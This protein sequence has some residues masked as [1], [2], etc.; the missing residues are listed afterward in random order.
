MCF[1]KE[2]R[3][4]ITVVMYYKYINNK[5][6]QIINTFYYYIFLRIN[7]EFTKYH[8]NSILH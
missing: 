8:Q 3:T 1:P 7:S 5:N 2:N 6:M 4:T